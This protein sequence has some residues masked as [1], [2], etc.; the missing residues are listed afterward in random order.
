[1][2]FIL[3]VQRGEQWLLATRNVQ[4]QLGLTGFLHGEPV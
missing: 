3:A 4:P 2:L 1:M